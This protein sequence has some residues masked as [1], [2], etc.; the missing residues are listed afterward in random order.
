MVS[1]GREILERSIQLVNSHPTW[2]AQVVYGDTDSL[3]VHLPGRSRSQAF[4][5]GQEIAA[6]VTKMYPKPIKLKFEKVYLPCLLQVRREHP[7]C[8][9]VCFVKGKVSSLSSSYPS[10]FDPRYLPQQ[11]KKRYVGYMYETPDQKEPVFDAKGIETVRRDG[12][13]AMAKVGWWA[14]H[15][16]LTSPGAN[17]SAY[18][19]V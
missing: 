16:T 11:T 1:K 15:T 5:I 18:L 9:F 4:V 12:C 8:I 2:A 10:L 7:L 17:N 13:P 14:P 19:P 3:F 6:A